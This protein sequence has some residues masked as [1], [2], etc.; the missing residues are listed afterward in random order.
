[1]AVRVAF[2]YK[3]ALLCILPVNPTQFRVSGPGTNQTENIVPTGDINILC[4]PGLREVTIESWIPARN[5]GEG[6]IN[7]DVVSLP[8]LSYVAF[9][10]GARVNREPILLVVTGYNVALTMGIESFDYWWEGADEDMHFSLDL[11]QWKSYEAKT[12]EVSNEETSNVTDPATPQDTQPRA[13]TAKKTA[14]GV[15]VLVNGQL[16]RDSQGNGPGQVEKNATRKISF[17]APGAPYPIH[18]STLEGGWR[19]WVAES[20]VSVV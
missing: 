15:T 2:Y 13:N 7:K 10:E 19:G 16:H 18:V 9:F 4:M 6:Y 5:N 14:V 3:N 20:A 17:L 11:K 1:M 8:A 12:I